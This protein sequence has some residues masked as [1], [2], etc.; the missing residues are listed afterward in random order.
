MINWNLLDLVEMALVVALLL[1]SSFAW[2]ASGSCPH[3]GQRARA[4]RQVAEVPNDD[5]MPQVYEHTWFDIQIPVATDAS[6]PMVATNTLF[7]SLYSK[8]GSDMLP[9]AV[10]MQENDYLVL[11]R[12]NSTSTS[13]TR[14][15]IDAIIPSIYHEL[16][17]I[18]HIPLAIFVLFVPFAQGD[19]P[20][21]MEDAVNYKSRC[22]SVFILS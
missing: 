11:L 22:V 16:K 14:D 2:L 18:C 21:P 6:D 9:N 10:V 7:Q 8:S 4:S 20:F 17:M 5:W 3:G 15:R 13:F 12:R 1:C 19:A